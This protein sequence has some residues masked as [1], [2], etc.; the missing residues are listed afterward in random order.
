MPKVVTQQRRGWASNP[1]LLDRKSDALPLSHRATRETVCFTYIPKLNP[2]SDSKQKPV[3]PNGSRPKTITLLALP[4]ACIEKRTKYFINQHRCCRSA[5]IHVAL[6]QFALSATSAGTVHDCTVRH[7]AMCI[8]IIDIYFID[9][10][11]RIPKKGPT[12][13]WPQL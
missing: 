6:G 1:R 12:V 10:K 13:S 5:R 3:S 8:D 9:S 11:Y 2:V 7:S 4:K